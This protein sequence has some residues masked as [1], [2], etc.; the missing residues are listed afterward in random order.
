MHEERCKGTG[1]VVRPASHRYLLGEAVEISPPSIII[2]GRSSSWPPESWKAGQDTIYAGLPIWGKKILDH[3]AAYSGQQGS[4]VVYVACHVVTRDLP[5]PDLK[6][7][8][9]E[10]Q[11]SGRWSKHTAWGFTQAI[12]K[13]IEAASEAGITPTLLSVGL[14]GWVSDVRM[15][16][17]W[18]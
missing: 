7:S 9:L 12:L 17:P 4:G 13:D 16:L 8:H 6:D 10:A 2:V 15:L 3:Y 18:L 5:A 1:A 14:D 11:Q